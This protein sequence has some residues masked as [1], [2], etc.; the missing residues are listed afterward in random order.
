MSVVFFAFRYELSA[1][2]KQ[3]SR[4]QEV[5][6]CPGGAAVLLFSAPCSFCESHEGHVRAGESFLQFESLCIIKKKTNNS[7]DCVFIYERVKCNVREHRL[8]GSSFLNLVSY[9]YIWNYCFG[10]L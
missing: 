8:R 5:M 4:F 3:L 1:V 9:E 6:K 2:F 10:N 7:E